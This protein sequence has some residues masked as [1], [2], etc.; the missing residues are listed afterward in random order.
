VDL[1]ERARSTYAVRTAR[2]HSIV[3]AILCKSQPHAD[4]ARGGTATDN[5]SSLDPYPAPSGSPL[6]AGTMD[7]VITQNPPG[8][9]AHCVRIFSNQRDRRD[10]LSGVEHVRTQ[11]IFREKLP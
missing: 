7:A 9:V 3:D 10:V 11:V 4:K 5:R 1:R 8:A 6:I 2:I